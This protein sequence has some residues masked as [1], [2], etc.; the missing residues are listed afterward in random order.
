MAVAELTTKQAVTFE[1]V[2]AA[3]E[4]IKALAKRTPVYT[5][6]LF[7]EAAGVKAYFKCENLQR[8]GAFKIRG[9]T[10]FLVAL[11]DE[12]RKRGIVAFS[13][14]NH[15]QAVAI[16]AAH[17]QI[18]ATIVMPTDAPQAKV[19]STL[20]YGPT[21]VFYDRQRES[22][23]EIA[24]R[25]VHQTGAVVLPP[26]DHPLIIAGQG[27]ATLE[28]LQE[29]PELEAL[30]VPLGGGGLLAGALIVAQELRPGMKVF[31][32][33]PELANDW[34]QSLQR[35]EPI[36]IAPPAT[37]ADGLRTPAPGQITFPI[38]R[39]SVGRALTV[40]EEEIKATLR[41]LLSRMKILVEPSG[42]VAAAV[43]LHRKLPALTG[44]VGILLSGGNVDFNVIADICREAA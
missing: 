35:G 22:R 23:E 11:S 21:V 37:I 36:R 42:A 3:A 9:A 1:D 15:A 25:I 5:S 12:E 30:L 39:Q 17:L 10:N 26:Y 41:F 32:V 33:E 20:A 6:R 27:T 7:D 4:R 29:Q 28:L 24:G 40:S 19:A 38:V 18:A 44:P 8:G 16:A 13:S 14:G 2:L 43:A 31:G 34:Y